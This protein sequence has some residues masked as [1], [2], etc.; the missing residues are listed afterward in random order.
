MNRCFMLS[1]SILILA[2]ATPAI[3]EQAKNFGDYEIHYVAFTTDILSPE[4][5]KSYNLTRSKNRALLNISVLKNVMGTS[6]QPVRAKVVASATNLSSQLKKFEIRELGEQGAIYY[7][8]EIP[9]NHRE[10]LKFNLNVTPDGEE[11]TYTFSFQQQ[12]FTE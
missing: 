2:V 5:A 3:A 12:F 11:N 9:V 6:S 10:T 1:L 7:I 8:A 4:V